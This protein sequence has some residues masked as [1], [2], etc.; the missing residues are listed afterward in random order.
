MVDA[1]S[2]NALVNSVA[3]VAPWLQNRDIVEAVYG[4]K[5]GVA[6]LIGVSK[7]AAAKGGEIIPAAGP[8]SAKGVLMPLGGYYYEALRGAIPAY[9]NKWNQASWEGWLNYLPADRGAALDKPLAI[10]HSE[11]AAIP[12]GVRAFLA[13]YKGKAQVTWLDNVDQFTFYDG[14]MPVAT[15]VNLVAKHFAGAK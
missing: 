14:K 3:L 4:G 8:V 12:Q 11:A 1:S 2:G 6:G 15:S 5:D 13:G 10:V 7:A 9:D